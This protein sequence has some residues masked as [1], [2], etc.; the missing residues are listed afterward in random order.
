MSK[1]W[2]YVDDELVNDDTPLEIE[3]VSDEDEA[4]RWVKRRLYTNIMPLHI[5]I[6]SY[7]GTISDN[8]FLDEKLT[9]MVFEGIKIERDREDK[10]VS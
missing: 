2:V 4:L 9:E 6:D 10:D 5:Y 1:W 8:D 7:R 3:G